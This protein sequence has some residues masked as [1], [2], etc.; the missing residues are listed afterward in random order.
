MRRTVSGLAA[1]LAVLGTVAAGAVAAPAAAAPAASVFGVRLAEGTAGLTL[2]LA[3]AYTLASRDAKAD[4]V[5][6]SITSGK[7]SRAEQAA[8]WR[9]GLATYGSPGQARRWVLPPGESTHVT[10]EAIDVGP[11]SGARWLQRHGSRYGLCRAFDNEWWHF[12]LLTLPGTACPPR[13][14]DA[15]HR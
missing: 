3:L 4:G 6:L 2:Q 11:R 15:S 1:V 14:R 7:R 9:D 10:G 5:P 12:E 13:L 8:L